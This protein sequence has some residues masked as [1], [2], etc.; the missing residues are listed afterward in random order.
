MRCH[1][2]RQNRVLSTV[3]FTHRP[4]AYAILNP[5]SN[6]SSPTGWAQSRLNLLYVRAPLQSDSRAY[7]GFQVR[8][9]ASS[10]RPVCWVTCCTHIH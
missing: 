8:R 6:G 4:Q 9:Y 7:A 5:H 3:A 10:H 2:G 1:D